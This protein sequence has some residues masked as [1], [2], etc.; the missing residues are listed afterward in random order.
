MTQF[1]EAQ[2]G[3]CNYT[4]GWGLQEKLSLQGSMCS[5]WVK[6]KKGVLRLAKISQSKRKANA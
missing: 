5:R 6:E 4:C 2:I 3:V 1:P